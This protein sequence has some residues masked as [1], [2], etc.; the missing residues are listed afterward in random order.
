MKN[1]LMF[2]VFV[3]ML[4]T[5]IGPLP[6]EAVRPP[7]NANVRSAVSQLVI[8][9]ILIVLMTRFRHYTGSKLSFLSLLLKSHVC[10]LPSICCPV[11]LFG[12]SKAAKQFQLS[13]RASLF[14]PLLG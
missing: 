2:K 6:A 13:L 10:S 3:M 9:G 8:N 11:K 4:V 1:H 12:S 14:F 5:C 7:A